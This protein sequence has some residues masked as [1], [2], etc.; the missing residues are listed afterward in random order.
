MIKVGVTNWLKVGLMAATF[1][2]VMKV[3]ANKVAPDSEA[4][5]VANTV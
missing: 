1:I 3:V 5:K 2:V 4:A